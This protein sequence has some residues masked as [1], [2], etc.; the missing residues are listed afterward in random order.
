VDSLRAA[1]KG[2]I[3]LVAEDGQCVLG[4]ILFS[5]V[6]LDGA[7]ARGL[8]R[9]VVVVGEPAYMRTLKEQCLYLHRFATLA[10]ARRI[11]GEFIDGY[12]AEWL[13]ERLG[14]RPP[15]ELRAGRGVRRGDRERCRRTKITVLMTPEEMDQVTKEEHELPPR[16]LLGCRHPDF[17]QELPRKLLRRPGSSTRCSA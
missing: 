12:N 9:S 3:S 16:Y 15:A 4:H 5:A 13:I 10:E 2:V 7:T 8:G 17:T 6:S 1:G 14:H 11:I